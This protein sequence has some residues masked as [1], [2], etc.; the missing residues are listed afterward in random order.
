MFPTKKR[1]C[2]PEVDGPLS[3][4]QSTSTQIHQN[5][6]LKRS[7]CRGLKDDHI[8]A[9]QKLECRHHSKVFYHTSDNPIVAHAHQIGTCVCPM[10]PPIVQSSSGHPVLH[11][12]PPLPEEGD[13]GGLEVSNG[14]PVSPHVPLGSSLGTVC[15]IQENQALFCQIHHLDDVRV[16]TTGR[17]LGFPTTISGGRGVLWASW[18]TREVRPRGGWRPR[19]SWQQDGDRHK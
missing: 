15:S 8:K 2:S 10:A 3:M 18:S 13:K 12:P 1:A 19:R 14:S 4:H 6:L 7:H 5:A 16:M 11:P 9:L 17:R